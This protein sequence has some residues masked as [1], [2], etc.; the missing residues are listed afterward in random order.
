[1][2][3]EFSVFTLVNCCSFSWPSIFISAY[4]KIA[5]DKKE[6]KKTKNKK[7]GEDFERRVSKKRD[8]FGVLKPFIQDHQE[9][10]LFHVLNYVIAAVRLVFTTCSFY[11]FCML[12]WRAIVKYYSN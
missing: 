1:M 7:K 8:I 3:P 6:T 5:K 10:Q 4:L 9:V 2:K 12:Q 11:L